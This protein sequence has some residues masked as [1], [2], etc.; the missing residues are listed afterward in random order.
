MAAKT[1]PSAKTSSPAAAAAT[2]TK[3]L[4]PSEPPSTT[5]S[6]DT[7]GDG[8]SSKALVQ[9][10]AG[11]CAV[12]A[13]AWAFST[14]SETKGGEVSVSGMAEDAIALIEA[15]GEMGPVYYT[16]FLAIWIAC[17]LPCS[18][19][20]VVPGFLYGVK[21]GFAVSLVGK[22]LG[23]TLSFL[24]CRTFFKAAL[25]RWFFDNYP[26][27]RVVGKA[28]EEEGL[29]V[30][31]VVRLSYVPMIF[32]NYGISVLDV[33]FARF[34]ASSALA[35]VPFS[36]LWASLG[37]SSRDLQS[38]LR[39]E[40]SLHDMLPVDP[41]QRVMLGVAVILV[42]GVAV[43]VVS[44]VRARVSEKM[45]KLALSNEKGDAKA[46]EAIS[47]A[48]KQNEE[49]TLAARGR[50]WWNIGAIGAILLAASVGYWQRESL[51]SLQGTM[52][53]AVD[54]IRAQGDVW[55]PIY[56]S[57]FLAVWVA[58]L[59]P[60]SVLEMVPGY[61]FGFRVG[62]VVSIL[63]KNLGTVM[64]LLLTRFFL[65]DMVQ[66]RLL[67]R[68]PILRTL[69]KAVKMEGFPVIVMIRCAY[70]PMIVKNYGLASLDIDVFKIW[71]A[72]IV[73]SIPFAAAWTAVGASA[74]NLADI[75]DGKMKL[76]D[77]LPE[78]SL[79]ILIVG[80]L[81]GALFLYAL[82]SFMKRFREILRE[83]DDDAVAAVK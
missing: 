67:T 39:G 4:S 74:T 22:I 83:A 8:S 40:R 2:T 58:A 3:T 29:P 41:M 68:F 62:V 49:E 20:E 11:A 64:S 65:R 31:V 60:C 56:Y 33:D 30:L 55:G 75:F 6:G 77:L 26:T 72:S 16:I 51:P 23:A 12:A 57:M 54:W 5:E 19:V 53:K 63:G 9:T 48:L 43:L 42:V 15:Q 71:I 7:R 36:L 38:I 37:A 13:L 44:K 21:V 1:R 73:S 50:I 46:A 32:K 14:Y 10:V 61:L 69:E 81:A 78:D 59:L 25:K 24:V 34:A 79:P 45:R 70:L 82:T 66:R 76:R 28:V 27:I 47:E 17:L 80:I 35:G 52:V 18:I